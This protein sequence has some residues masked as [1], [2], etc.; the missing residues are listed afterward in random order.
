LGHL[1]AINYIT[2]KCDETF[3]LICSKKGESP[4]DDRKPFEYEER[5]RMIE[6]SMG[7]PPKVHFRHIKDQENDQE[8]TRVIEKEIPKGRIVSFSNNPHTTNAFKA[9]GYETQSIP[10]KYDNLNAT[11]IRK[12]II[13][14]QTWDN[15]V[16]YGTLVVVNEI[17]KQ[18]YSG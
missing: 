17:R 8:W 14:N 18:L 3:V 15:L 6:L 13:R 10:I 1:E 2:S 16:P 5:K 4:L 12:L 7:L 9:H 11:L